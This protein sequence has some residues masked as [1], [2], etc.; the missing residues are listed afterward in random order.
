MKKNVQ[1]DYQKRHMDKHT[2]WKIIYE[3]FPDVA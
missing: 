3:A 2:L 1:E